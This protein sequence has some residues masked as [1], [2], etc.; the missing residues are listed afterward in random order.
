MTII[1]IKINKGT[2]SSENYYMFHYILFFL[3]VKKS[4]SGCEIR[5][6][7]HKL[8]KSC[9]VI[10]T[11][12]VNHQCISL[13]GIYT[14]FLNKILIY[15]HRFVLYLLIYRLWLTHSSNH[16]SIHQSKPQ[17][18]QKF[19]HHFFF[20]NLKIFTRKSKVIKWLWKKT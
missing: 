9:H 20:I 12:L 14:S 2:W 19:K 11:P 3:S 8:Y 4:T 18:W 1:G 7:F 17:H 10:C 6:K 5:P 16:K 15:P 13:R